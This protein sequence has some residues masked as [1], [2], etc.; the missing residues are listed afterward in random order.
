MRLPALSLL[1]LGSAVSAALIHHPGNLLSLRQDVATPPTVPEDNNVIALPLETD[2]AT[3]PTAPEDDNSKICDL[4]KT[5]T[6]LLSDSK[7][8]DFLQTFLK[9]NG[10]EDWLI[11]ME[12]KY[13]GPNFTPEEPSC[14][15]IESSNCYPSKDCR[16]FDNKNFFYVRLISGYI[17]QFFT[18][19]HEDLQDQTITDLLSV[20]EIIQDYNPDK[21]GSVDPKALRNAAGAMSASDKIVKNIPSLPSAGKLG[22]ALGFIGAIMSIF[23]NNAPIPPPFDF[24][25]VAQVATS[26]LRDTFKEMDRVQEEVLSRLFGNTDVDMSLS[27]VVS[28]MK[29]MG[30]E[31]VDSDP[32]TSIMSMAW[33]GGFESL[34]MGKVLR[35]T[36]QQTNQGLV[37]MILA[38]IG[39]VVVMAKDKTESTCNMPGASWIDGE[40]FA[41]SKPLDGDY[42]PYLE[43]EKVKKLWEKYKFDM[44]EFYKNVKECKGL[45]LDE[46]TDPGTIASSTK[47]PTCFFSMDYQTLYNC[48]NHSCEDDSDCDSACFDGCDYSF[49]I[50]GG[51]CKPKE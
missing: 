28:K 10:D 51:F 37:G 2:T 29:G 47:Y 31:M 16:E 39:N 36:L 17:N 40:C 24:N 50:M 34:D 43:E 3:R 22:D 11:K 18:R 41:V 14:G 19:F 4:P 35:D 7:S 32:I 9:K 48:P 49:K 46:N 8:V 33:G 21:K 1:A 13:I 42:Y 26:Y 6:T 30:I 5:G 44:V 20:N 38:A 15:T 23:A 45:N 12:K 27:D 25:G